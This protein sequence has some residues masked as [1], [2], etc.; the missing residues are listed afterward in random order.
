MMGGY[1]ENGGSPMNYARALDLNNEKFRR[2]T[3]AKKPTFMK[4]VKILEE[5]HIKKKAKGGR[6]NKLKVPEMLLMTLEYLREYRTYFHI[7]AS[8]GLAE[9]NAY[10]AIQ[11]V[12]NT[13]VK[14]R[15]F[16]LPG[17]KALASSSNEIEV[18]LVDAT[19]TPVQRPKKNRK[20]T[21]PARKNGT[22]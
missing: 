16:S 6:P 21:T 3:G 22:Q 18:I 4:M 11:W 14:S 19:E 17:K 13:L 7:G 5:E 15:Q 10:Q 8:Y 12:E 2:L 20:N 9:S 1:P